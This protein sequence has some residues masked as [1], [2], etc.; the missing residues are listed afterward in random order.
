[1]NNFCRTC[2]TRLEPDSKFCGICGTALAQPTPM[3]IPLTA[4]PVGR[5]V[6]SNKAVLMPNLTPGSLIDLAG[7]VGLGIFGLWVLCVVGI[8][9]LLALI[10]AM[11]SALSPE[12]AHVVRQTL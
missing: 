2:G 10:V 7:R 3:P 1:V 11:L 12:F 8:L 6:A 4:A 5:P 9:V